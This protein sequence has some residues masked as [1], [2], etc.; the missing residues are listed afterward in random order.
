MLNNL[1]PRSKRLSVA[2]A[3][4]TSIAIPAEGV[5]QWAY[6]DPVGILTVCYGTTGKDVVKGRYYSLPECKGFLDRDML[7]AV[8]T[9]E[10][11]HP[12]LPEPVLA[13][14]GDAVYNMGPAV[15]CNSTA[16][17]LLDAGEIQSA[18]RQLPRWNKASVA[19]VMVA[20]PGLTTRRNKEM[21]LC[22]SAY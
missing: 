8:D 17:R 4:A 7:D 6:S 10:R 22:L 1:G 21:A 11:C 5:R 14:F 18:C 9:V 20:L 13:A 15:A 3:L 16:S 19:G 12:G 2:V